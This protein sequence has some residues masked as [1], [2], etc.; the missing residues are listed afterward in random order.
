M[1]SGLWTLYLKSSLSITLTPTPH[2]QMPIPQ[3]IMK[4]LETTFIYIYIWKSK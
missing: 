2:V 1:I 3:H 4:N